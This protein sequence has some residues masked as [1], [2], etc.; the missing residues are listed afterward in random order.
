MPVP[1]HIGRLR[2]RVYNQ[3]ELLAR[4]CATRLGVPCRSELLL[5]I[6]PMPPQVGLSLAE[7]RA[8]VRDA[9]ALAKDA[10]SSL[11][12][13]RV[14]LIDDV[15][16]TGSTL[17]AAAAAIVGLAVSRPDLLDA[18]SDADGAAHATPDAQGRH[19]G[20]GGA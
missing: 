5:R 20:R 6:R 11:A 18:R 19:H 1:L 16:N 8:N 15:A 14:L 9:F 4:R 13:K 2:E 3:A 7:R 17:D 10:T 12:G